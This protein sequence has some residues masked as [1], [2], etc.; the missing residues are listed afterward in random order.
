M[1]QRRKRGNLYPGST[2]LENVVKYTSES[3]AGIILMKIKGVT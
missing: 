1:F 2:W 3:M